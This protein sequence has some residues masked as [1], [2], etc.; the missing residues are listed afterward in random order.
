MSLRP[1]AEL[2]GE[3][4]QTNPL[5]KTSAALPK[6]LSMTTFSAEVSKQ[7]AAVVERQDQCILLLLLRKDWCWGVHLLILAESSYMGRG[8]SRVCK[9]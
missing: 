8:L 5:N 3:H 2:D 6:Q 4:D 7:N 1:S 9:M